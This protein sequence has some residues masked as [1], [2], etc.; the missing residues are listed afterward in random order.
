MSPVTARILAAVRTSV[1]E[2]SVT[3]VPDPL[4][5]RLARPR[6]APRRGC[7]AGGTHA[8]HRGGNGGTVARDRRGQPRRD[9]GSEEEDGWQ[10]H[11]AGE[12]RH[13][14]PVRLQVDREAEP[15][16]DRDPE[17][18]AEEEV[19]RS[20]GPWGR[21]ARVSHARGGPAA[22]RRVRGPRAP[23][24]RGTVAQPRGC[25]ST[26]ATLPSERP[27]TSAIPG[28]TSAVRISRT[29]PYSACAIRAARAPIAR[30]GPRPHAPRLRLLA[31]S[32][33]L[34]FIGERVAQLLREPASAELLSE[35]RRNSPG[36]PA[37]VTPRLFGA[38][39]PTRDVA[40][41]GV[42]GARLRARS[43]R[44]LSGSPRAG[45]RC[46]GDTSSERRAVTFCQPVR[47]A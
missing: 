43:A 37:H 13:Q 22:V 4:A 9:D 5:G 7:T 23:L 30:T 46:L 47:W 33:P 8:V 6:S 45:A 27:A 3:I 25:F 36:H 39:E 19:S 18:Q 2:I 21:H 10:P 29:R 26:Y 17:V 24:L 12:K 38:A 31:G 20:A 32:E 16:H 41:A 28:T 1:P 15:P 11:H 40:S 35:R 44:L 34:R 14:R 42:H